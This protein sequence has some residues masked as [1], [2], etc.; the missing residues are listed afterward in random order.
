MSRRCAAD[1]SLSSRSS[2]VSVATVASEIAAAIAVAIAVTSSSSTV[3][4]CDNEYWDV[5]AWDGDVAAVGYASLEDVGAY[6]TVVVLA[7]ARN[8]AS[9]AVVAVAFAAGIAIAALALLSTVGAVG[10]GAVAAVGCA[11]SIG[12]VGAY[13]TVVILAGA[14][15]GA[16]AAVVAVVVAAGVAVAATTS[17][18]WSCCKYARLEIC[19]LMMNMRVVFKPPIQ[20]LRRASK[21]VVL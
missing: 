18:V 15:R 21:Q 14:R 10:D 20:L 5:A 6:C 9:A 11:S 7:G 17:R 3:R 19:F 12:D 4:K 8:G 16:V 13:R 2:K 1:I